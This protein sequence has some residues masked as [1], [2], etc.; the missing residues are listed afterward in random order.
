MTVAE[1]PERE[2]LFRIGEVAER[3]GTPASR[4]RHARSQRSRPDG[5]SYEAAR[6]GTARK[7]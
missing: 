5:L 3:T 4:A 7:S 1:A 2:H 6:L